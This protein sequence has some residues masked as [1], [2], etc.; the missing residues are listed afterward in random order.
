MRLFDR[1]RSGVP[2][3]LG[4]SVVVLVAGGIAAV[5]GRTP[6]PVVQL[7]TAPVYSPPP[8]PGIGVVFDAGEP[9]DL[10]P[11]T[12]VPIT[13]LPSAPR[14]PGN[15]TP[16]TGVPLKPR[17]IVPPATAWTQ[18][19]PK[20]PAAS[21][22]ASTLTAITVSRS[23]TGDLGNGT[24]WQPSLSADGRFVAYTSDASNLVVD[25]TNGVQDVFVHDLVSH[26][27]VRASVGSG[28]EQAD[29]SSTWPSIS[30][31]GSL[32]A[33]QS[34][35]ASLGATGGDLAVFLHD[36]HSGT[37]TLIAQA[38]MAPQI[39]NDGRWLLWTDRRTGDVVLLDRQT[40]DA[41][42]LPAR[43]ARSRSGRLTGD[44][45][46]F[47]FCSSAAVTDSTKAG[48]FEIYVYDIDTRRF[49][50]L[51]NPVP[52]DPN[53]QSFDPSA[54]DDGSA[55]VFSSNRRLTPD[56]TDD[57]MDTF[58]RDRTKGTTTMAPRNDSARYSVR[59]QA[60][61]GDGR[62][63]AI[64]IG[65]ADPN[66]PRND[67]FAWERAT[68]RITRLLTTGG[69]PITGASAKSFDWSTDGR[70][71]AA[72]GTGPGFSDDEPAHK[73]SQIVIWRSP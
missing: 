23:A 18:G 54:S 57:W 47:V 37:T 42:S 46:H 21:G 53:L 43:A 70:T 28:G 69:T 40:G 62:M 33:F 7:E 13:A 72:S 64:G 31:D 17:P 11:A 36:M 68:G 6:A 59:E 3:V 55:V 19:A 9:A 67:L 38:A 56:D 25:D 27:T 66:D 2:A 5:N 73:N 71:L 32:V 24:S 61:S 22:K 20:P 1:C 14:P 44:G 30:G 8:P 35:A 4:L 51:S 29:G 34:P 65:S 45:R 63:V 26:D 60:I 10:T 48:Y 15:L 39:S 49:D 41:D 16:S 50:L 58:L 52:G 12:T